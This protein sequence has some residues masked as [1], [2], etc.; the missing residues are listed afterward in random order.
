MGLLDDQKDPNQQQPA[1]GDL[2]SDLLD[3]VTF[4]EPPAKTSKGAAFLGK[5]LRRSEDEE[6]QTEGKAPRKKREKKP[7]QR[8]RR[9]LTGKQLLI[10]A[11]LG[12]L[13]IG[14]YITLVM[15]I[16]R[17]TPAE[18]TP[19]PTDEIVGSTATLET[20]ATAAPI[21]T[22]TPAP[23]ATEPSSANTPVP[24][25]PVA[26]RFD[27]NIRVNP[28]NVNMRVERGNEY[29][30]LGAFTAALADFEHALGVDEN[31]ADAHT[32]AGMAHYRLGHWSEAENG[33]LTAIALDSNLTEPR[34]GLGML[35]YLQ[36]RYREAAR[37]FDAAAEINPDYAEAEA[38]LA[39][40]SA[41][42]HDFG[43]AHGAAT[44]A[45]SVTQDIAIV[46]IARAWSQLALDPPNI[47]AAQGDLLYAQELD[48]YNFELLIALARFYTD[49]RPERLIEAEQ[50]A[51]YALNWA[52]GDMQ[53]AR[54]LHSLGHVY[55]AQGRKDDA[56]HKLTDAADLTILD[57][58]IVLAGLA[59]DL[60]RALAP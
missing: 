12:I 49:Y 2:W 44:R 45:I 25:P 14:A 15:I 50:L 56:K 17:T 46:Y 52:K 31:R 36:G 6:K 39:I 48:P 34:F 5:L 20:L 41:E 59:E 21:S 8:K 23:Q 47:D 16:Q 26:T 13:V 40:T 57:G 35:Y 30:N 38:W 54:S 37:A 24:T 9:G 58:R 53:R 4:E 22:Q 27:N 51:T 55:L 43:E 28:D 32:G 10:L 60:Q 19:D 18:V 42:M 1:D 33:F 7:R 3:G 11:V 29:L